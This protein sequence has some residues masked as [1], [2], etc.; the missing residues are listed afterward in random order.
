APGGAAAPG[1]ELGDVGAV[2]GELGGGPQVAVG[3]GQAH[4]HRRR[5]HPVGEQGADD[6]AGAG[7]HVDVEVVDRE[8][9][10]EVVEGAERP[11]LVG[12]PGDPSTA[13]HQCATATGGVG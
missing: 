3:P 9:D 10:E 13:Q 4:R 2:E 12:E 7:P 8:I 6:R 5:A 1:R 11:D